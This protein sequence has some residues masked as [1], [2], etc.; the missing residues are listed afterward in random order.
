MG[1]KKLLRVDVDN[2]HLC[3]ADGDCA[4]NVHK[5]V[6]DYLKEKHARYDS[7]SVIIGPKSD[8]KD[9]IQFPDFPDFPEMP[10]W[11][12][13]PEWDTKP[14]GNVEAPEFETV[15]ESWIP[16][17][18]NHFILYVVLPL[19]MTVSIALGVTIGTFL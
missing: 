8:A 3:Q 1:N 2:I 6:E 9:N 7:L 12:A 16:M 14:D 13:K 4:D 5:L 11:P 19:V 15:Y 10:D 18:Q 17:K